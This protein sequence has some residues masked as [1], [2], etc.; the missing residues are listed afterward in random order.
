M[1]ARGHSKQ[2][3]YRGCG[4]L[5]TFQSIDHLH[6]ASARRT[7]AKPK[8]QMSV[9]DNLSMI[10]GLCDQL[11][12]GSKDRMSEDHLNEED[13]PPVIELDT[14]GIVFATTG[15]LYTDLAR[16][17]ARTIRI[18]MPDVLIDL[19]TDQK[20]DDPVFDKVHRLSGTGHRPK[21]EALRRT[22]FERT[23]IL[24]AD[25]IVLADISELFE[26]LDRYDMAG[27]QAAKR[28]ENMTPLDGQT[29]SCLNAINTGVLVV[30][31]SPRIQAFARA[32]EADLKSK[33]SL[34][35]QPAFRRLLYQSDLE[36]VTL[37][38]AYNCIWLDLLEIWNS[39]LGA[40]RI[41]H[42]ISLHKDH[43]GDPEKPFDLVEAIGEQRARHVENLL[44]A[45]WMLGGDTAKEV[46]TSPN[47]LRMERL[48]ELD[49]SGMQ[50]AKRGKVKR[51]PNA[52][53]NLNDQN[54]Q[55]PKQQLRRLR[56]DLNSAISQIYDT[57]IM[58]LASQGRPVRIC[59]V[60]ANDGKNGD[61][62][63]RLVR[64]KLRSC[65]E[66]TLFEPQ[67]YL[68]PF[69][70]S[71]YSFHH[72][73]CIVPAAV[74]PEN[75]LTFARHSP[76]TLETFHPPVRLGLAVLSGAYRGDILQPRQCPSVGEQA[77]AGRTRSG[78]PD[79]RTDRSIQ[80][81]AS[82]P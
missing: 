65:T 63:Y 71:N 67:E 11:R 50:A 38:P 66:I 23:V 21:I 34:V 41:L 42:V 25:I 9:A 82:F 55:R 30:K 4:F 31:A 36:F 14:R 48:K 60:G 45:D 5:Q 24:D 37:G 61:P 2:P 47:N 46:K 54:N 78:K 76:G 72:S 17:A 1:R 44:A 29:P 28:T 68:I 80:A 33:Q 59:V 3:L 32:W 18:V 70:E 39:N 12:I 20:I 6:E 51:Q 56:Q 43:P 16:R 69:L 27:V 15:K 58:A 8:V 62:L 40:P 77:S 49:S 79:R 7:I 13:S 52:G 53:Q 57:S 26:V 64:Q 81:A 74:G 19:F 35:D 75:T 22:R 10:T 73:H